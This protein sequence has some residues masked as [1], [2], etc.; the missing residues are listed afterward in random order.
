[1]T[2][3]PVSR[4]VPIGPGRIVWAVAPSGR[5]E[6]KKRPLIIATRRV[7]I[8]KGSAIAAVGCSTEFGEPLEPVEIRLPFDPEGKGITGL[9]QDTVAVCD[10]VETFPPGTDF[11][12][13]GMVPGLL[14]TIFET[15]GIVVPPER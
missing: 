4:P 15:A 10:W 1:M 11:E 3:R 2:P 8:L 5:G 12:T 6:G 13:G 9:R 7:D 14:R